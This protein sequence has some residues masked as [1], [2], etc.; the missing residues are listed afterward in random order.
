MSVDLHTERANALY[1]A[2][3]DAH[4]ALDEAYEKYH[5]AL[6]VALEITNASEEEMLA[7]RR[8][9]LAYAHALTR[10][11]DAAMAWLTYVDTHLRPKRADSAKEGH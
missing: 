2:K 7:L 1:K 5:H 8:E 9:G 11:T 3:V 6:A 10:Y 4:K